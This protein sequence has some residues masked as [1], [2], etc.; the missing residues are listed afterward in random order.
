MADS[1]VDRKSLGKKN[2]AKGSVAERYYRDQFRDIGYDKCVTSR[3]GS[4]LHDNAGIDLILV[5][6]N[7]Q[8]KVGEQKGLKPRE[9]LISMDTKMRNLFPLESNEFSVPKIVIHK[10][11]A[12]GGKRTE[13]DEIV[14]M[15][16]K[17]FK[18]MAQEIYD[19]QSILREKEDELRSLKK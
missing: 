11:Y 12:E 4:R 15:T 9:E 2:K 3:L 14:T 13:F 10:R 7:V 19:L 16:F 8:V 18:D 6:Y 17:D 1:N 5:P